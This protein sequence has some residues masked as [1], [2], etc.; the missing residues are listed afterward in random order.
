MEA[1]ERGIILLPLWLR[2]V[3]YYPFKT[4]IPYLNSLVILL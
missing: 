3:K 2:E 1:E 4:Q